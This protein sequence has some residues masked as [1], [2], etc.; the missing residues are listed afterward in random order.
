VSAL[1]SAPAGRLADRYGHRVV[2]VPGT[3]LY[4]LGISLLVWRLPAEPNYWGTYFPAFL[5]TGF[6]VGMTIATIGAASNAFLPP[7]RFAMGGAVN[8]TVRQVGAALGI[9]IVVALLG[10]APGPATFDRA[11][12]FVA[13]TAVAAGLLMWAL[14]RPPIMPVAESAPATA[15]LLVPRP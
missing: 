6:G 3:L 4:A 12:T 1:V 7:T 5:L 13:G 11:F 9:A 15:D 14:Y 8:A 2:V 10:E